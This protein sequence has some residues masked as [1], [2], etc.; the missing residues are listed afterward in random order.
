MVSSVQNSWSQYHDSTVQA[1]PIFSYMSQVCHHHSL[2]AC[3]GY[4]GWSI[5]EVSGEIRYPVL[6]PLRGRYKARNAPTANGG[7][8]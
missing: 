5:V 3:V 1:K 7:L 6:K 8:I 2:D 4:F